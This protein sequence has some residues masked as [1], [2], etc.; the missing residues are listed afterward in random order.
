MRRDNEVTRETIFL[1]LLYV[2]TGTAIAV[3]FIN[4]FDYTR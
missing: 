4:W 1:A 2:I 3:G